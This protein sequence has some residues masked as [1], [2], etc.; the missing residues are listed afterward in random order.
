MVFSKCI[1]FQR[2]LFWV[3]TLVFGDDSIKT[4]FRPLVVTKKTRRNKNHL[5]SNESPTIS[6]GWRYTKKTVLQHPRNW[7]K[8][9]N[10][11]LKNRRKHVTRFS[12]SCPYWFIHV[13]QIAVQWHFCSSNFVLCRWICSSH[14]STNEPQPSGWQQCSYTILSW[15]LAG[16][17]F[18]RVTPWYLWS[19]LTGHEAQIDEISFSEWNSIISLPTSK[20]VKNK[21]RIKRIPLDTLYIGV[22]LHVITVEFTM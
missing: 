1:C 15:A 8:P 16:L 10:N 9:P 17:Y 2:W 6:A 3:T 18:K 20:R 14:H 21:F 5:R 11:T 13:F 4:N 22:T 12:P 7:P 19:W